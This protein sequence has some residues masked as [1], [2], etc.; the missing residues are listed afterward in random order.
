M[1]KTAFNKIL[2]ISLA[3]VL[4]FSACASASDATP[5]DAPNPQPTTTTPPTPTEEIFAISVNGEKISAEELSLEIERVRAVDE[6]NGIN[7]SDD[8]R[9]AY[10]IDEMIGTTLLAQDAYVNGFVYTDSDHQIRVD[11]LVAELGSID[12][13]NSWLIQNGYA[14]ES[15]RQALE[16]AIAAAFTRDRITALVPTT[17]KQFHAQELLLYDLPTAEYYYN[18]YLA[19]ADFNTLSL[20]IDPITRG[21][22]G[23]FPLGYLPD[24]TIE[25]AIAQMEV[26]QVSEII[27][28]EVGFYILKLLEVDENRNL[29]PDALIQAQKKAL[30]DWIQQKRSESEIIIR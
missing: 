9:R 6:Q 11:E 15:F 18:Q 5:T 27:E 10:T 30:N 7:R 22:I 24:P 28:G 8:E 12:S 23:W 2:L 1:K 16:H 17:G 13:L 14:Q 4:L 25:T 26:G 3:A 29:S 20:N 19:G 21:D